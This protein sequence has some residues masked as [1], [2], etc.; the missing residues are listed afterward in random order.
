MGVRKLLDDMVPVHSE[1]GSTAVLANLNKGEDIDIL[2]IINHDNQQWVRIQLIDKSIGYILGSTQISLPEKSTGEK[3]KIFAGSILL[4]YT[5]WSGG[6]YIFDK[7]TGNSS[8]PGGVITAGL[9]SKDKRALSI[10]IQ[11]FNAQPWS[12]EYRAKFFADLNETLIEYNNESSKNSLNRTLL[13]K[14]AFVSLRAGCDSDPAILRGKQMLSDLD[15][16]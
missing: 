12:R 7:F 9:T 15:V 2:E 3:I 6:S 11:A 14:M 4:I 16:Q 13:Y 1:P 5:V 10:Y 8:I